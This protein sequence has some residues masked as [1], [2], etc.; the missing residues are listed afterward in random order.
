VEI[1]NHH[2]DGEDVSWGTQISDWD[3]TPQEEDDG[4]WIEGTQLPSITSA[5]HSRLKWTIAF[6]IV[7]GAALTAV[8][9]FATLLVLIELSQIG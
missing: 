4:S 5:D 1:L 2:P 3:D 9:G 7:I 8:A 6:G